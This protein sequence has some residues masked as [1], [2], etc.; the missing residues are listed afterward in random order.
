[1]YV[2][3]NTTAGDKEINSYIPQYIAKYCG[4]IVAISYAVPP[5][6]QYIAI[7][8]YISILQYIAISLQYYLNI[9]QYIVIFQYIARISNNIEVYCNTV[10]YF[11]KKEAALG[12][13]NRSGCSSAPRAC[14]LQPVQNNYKIAVRPGF[15]LLTRALY[16]PVYTCTS[17]SV[18]A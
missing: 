17:S 13:G 18:Y 8:Q 3:R 1:M 9:L 7:L 11:D 6:L 10:I 5:I 16:M 15:C 12:E 14:A 4:H 2:C